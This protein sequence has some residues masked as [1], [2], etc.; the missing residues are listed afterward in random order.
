MIKEKDLCDA[1]KDVY[2]AV[3]TSY[4]DKLVCDDAF[5]LFRPH[6]QKSA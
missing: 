2:N 1:L 6:L 4:M 5:K 3:V